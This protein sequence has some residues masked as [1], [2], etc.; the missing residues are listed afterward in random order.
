MKS[1]IGEQFM[2]K[3]MLGGLE[4]KEKKETVLG[5]V[6]FRKKE[7]L[8][9]QDTIKQPPSFPEHTLGTPLQAS[10]L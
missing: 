10:H 1:S 8:K 5:I 4:E 6:G 2:G 7:C 3:T 9:N